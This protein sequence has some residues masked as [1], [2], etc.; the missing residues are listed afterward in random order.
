MRLRPLLPLSS[1]IVLV[2]SPA[3]AT[4]PPTPS[5]P[6][7][8]SEVVAIT[9]CQEPDFKTCDRYGVD[10]GTAYTIPDPYRAKLGSARTEPAGT[11]CTLFKYENAMGRIADV[12]PS[13]VASLTGKPTS[14]RCA[15][16]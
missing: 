9:L 13:G 14:F 3:F 7:A 12:T 5:A 10:T 2:A 4:P 6:S 11:T 16:A 15:K 1:V 8:P